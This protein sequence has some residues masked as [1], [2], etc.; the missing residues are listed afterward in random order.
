[1]TLKIGI[2]ISIVINISLIIWVINLIWEN[3][4]MTYCLMKY[5]DYVTGRIS[6]EKLKEDLKVNRDSE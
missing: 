3:S 4:G 2:I 6:L 1:M 5:Q